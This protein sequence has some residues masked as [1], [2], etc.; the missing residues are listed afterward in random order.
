[1]SR[2]SWPQNV[3]LDTDDCAGQIAIF[4]KNFLFNGKSIKSEKDTV[5][6]KN[7]A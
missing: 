1:M 3:V 2:Q 4:D 5:K 7:R 6:G